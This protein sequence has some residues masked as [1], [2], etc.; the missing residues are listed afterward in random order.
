MMSAHPLFFCISVLGNIFL[1]YM[2]LSLVEKKRTALLPPLAL[3]TNVAFICWR[4]PSTSIFW[5]PFLIADNI[6]N[7][8]FGYLLRFALEHIF[9]PCVV[10]R[11]HSGIN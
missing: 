5:S 3:F 2:L 7:Y 11:N 6:I 4:P 1:Y 10:G 9:Y 8:F